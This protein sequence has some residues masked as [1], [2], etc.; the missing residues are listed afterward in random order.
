MF[1]KQ[2]A[3]K[4][5]KIRSQMIISKRFRQDSSSVSSIETSKPHLPY[6]FGDKQHFQQV[7]FN[8]VDNAIKFTELGTVLI[9]SY[10]DEIER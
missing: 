7:L 8:L 6:L 2:A 9:L 5:I 4:G 3:E 1:S 10:Y